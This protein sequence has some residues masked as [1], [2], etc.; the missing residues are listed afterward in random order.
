[1]T[2]EELKELKVQVVTELRGVDVGFYDLAETDSR[3]VDYVNGVRYEPEVHNLYEVLAVRKFFRL[4]DR[5]V[6]KPEKVRMYIRFYENLKFSGLKG[7]RKYRLTPIQVFQF[8]SM[9]G[10]YE[11]VEVTDDDGRKKVLPRRVVREAILFVPRKFGKTTGSASL[12]VFELLFGDNNAQCFVGANSYKQAQICF[13]EI[14]KI[15]KQFDPNKKYFKTTREHI[16]WMDT[17]SL[18]KESYCE[19]LTGGGDTKDGL[20][21]SLVIFDEYAQAKY[22][23]DHSDGAELLQVLQSSMG[24]RWEPLTVIITTASRVPDGPFAFMLENAKR[25]LLGEWEDDS[26]FASL[27]MPDEWDM[28]EEHYGDE[29]IWR[30]C[31]PHIGVTVQNRYY[32]DVWQKALHDPEVMLEFKTKLLNVFVQD[33]AQQWLPGSLIR[34]LMTAGR[35]E[36][37]T[38][39]PEAMVSIDLS[40]SDDFSCVCYTVYNRVQ[41]RFSAFCDF[42]I[43]E[44]TLNEHPNKEL[45]KVW[46]RAGW[47][48]VCKG[49]VIDGRMIVE[50]I[51]RNNKYV[52]ILQIGYDAYKSK[53]VVNM[54]SAAVQA[55]GGVPDNV[56][57]AVP[58]TYGAF[59]SPV[60]TLEI[61]AKSL[62]TRIDFGDNG[63][64]AYCFDNAFLD[65]DKM[66][67]KK[68]IKRKRNLKIDAVV[69]VLMCF[70]LFNNFER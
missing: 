51:V 19:C 38:G 68:P 27:F 48:K 7:R 33:G 62:P 58:Q 54:L 5:Y 23:K 56:M 46:V 13:R 69:C 50:D 32:A 4:L 60:E 18:G 49:A 28:S 52:R 6:W 39:R 22:V 53:E 12:P 21:A 15:V 36:S 35:I 1:M 16:E 44:E 3:L 11:N 37:L 43:P 55:L 2:V 42:Y 63:I 70:W 64:V 14:K 59:T 10:F 67:N 65:E 30:M 20:A 41:R 17:N 34:K 57:R 26:Q 25:V 61:A 45:Y 40:V 31:N 29:R 9:L 24:T 8:A 47:L 66:E